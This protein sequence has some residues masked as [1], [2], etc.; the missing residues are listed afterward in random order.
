M[1]GSS[2]RRRAIEEAAEHNAWQRGKRDHHQ[3]ER[4]GLRVG[5]A[6][7]VVPELGGQRLDPG[8]YQDQRCGELGDDFK[9]DQAEGGRQAGR[10]EAQR[11]PAERGQPA[12]AE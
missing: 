6:G 10:R 7:L 8:G 12:L 9:E 2:C 11:D 4:R 5:Q 1:P 3:G